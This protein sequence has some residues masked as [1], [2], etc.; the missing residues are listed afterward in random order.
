MKQNRIEK[1]FNVICVN[2]FP[3]KVFFQVVLHPQSSHLNELTK[4]R[5]LAILSDRQPA[6]SVTSFFNIDG[7]IHKSILYLTVILPDIL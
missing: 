3:P 7:I 5:C 1:I 2:T 6:G 4:L